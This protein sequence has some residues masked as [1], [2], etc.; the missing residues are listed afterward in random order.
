MVDNPRKNN[1][2]KE[3]SPNIWIL[4]I[5][6]LYHIQILPDPPIKDN[7]YWV[8]CIN[9]VQEICTSSLISVMYRQL[10]YTESVC[11]LC[12]WQP[13]NSSDWQTESLNAHDCLH[14]CIMSY[15]HIQ[16]MLHFLNR[17]QYT[18]FVQFEIDFLFWPRSNLSQGC[19]SLRWAT[20]TRSI[21]LTQN[22][23]L[24]SGTAMQM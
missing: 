9:A 20:H 14:A 21:H 22:F 19:C 2:N 15:L 3:Q 10:S 7:C 13:R 23:P 18:W 11:R 24:K 16:H 6:V 8:L 4:T 5:T 17:E 1:P 12:F